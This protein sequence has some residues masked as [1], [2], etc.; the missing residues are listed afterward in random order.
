ML[1][2]LPL[3]IGHITTYADIDGFIV[4]MPPLPPFRHARHYRLLRADYFFMSAC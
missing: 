4:S 3:I 2:L 1:P